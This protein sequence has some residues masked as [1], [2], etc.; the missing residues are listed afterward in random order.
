MIRETESPDTTRKWKIK[1]LKR[2]LKIVHESYKTDI[3]R[4]IKEL[5]EAEG[6]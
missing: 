3:K 2:Q 4:R 5:E 1:D 6:L